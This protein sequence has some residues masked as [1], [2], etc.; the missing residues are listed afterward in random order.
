MCLGI[1]VPV[2]A[3]TLFCATLQ[4]GEECLGAILQ[5]RNGAAG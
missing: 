3:T 1:H 5:K 4:V 2:L